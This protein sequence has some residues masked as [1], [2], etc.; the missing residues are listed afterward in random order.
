MSLLLESGLYDDPYPDSESVQSGL[1]HDSA[2]EDCADSSLGEEDADEDIEEGEEDEDEEDGSPGFR[3]RSR[4]PDDDAFDRHTFLSPKKRG[5]RP[6][7]RNS[8]KEKKEPDDQSKSNYP[9]S[10]QA[11]A[12]RGWHV[13][14]ADLT[15]DAAN[16][17]L[18]SHAKAHAPGCGYRK[19]GSRNHRSNGSWREL[20]QCGYVAEVPCCPALRCLDY[21]PDASGGGT[22]SIRVATGANYEH[23]TH[24]G[25]RVKG[26]P[27]AVYSPPLTCMPHI[28]HL[29]RF[30]PELPF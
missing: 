29:Q 2:A 28:L 27:G 15:W 17:L 12:D 7:S 19:T 3:G 9:T 20:Q 30:L 25:Y 18:I 11:P 6:R 14:S 24:D 23:N 22:Y 21:H 10:R 8:K 4:D 1:Q 5:K 16:D 26:P 13:L